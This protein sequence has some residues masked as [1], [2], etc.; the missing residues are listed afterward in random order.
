MGTICLDVDGVV[1]DICASLN[2]E[3]ED[4]RGIFN[5]DYSDW[6]ITPFENNLTKEIFSSKTFWKN[7]KPFADAWYCIN[8]WWSMG[9]DINLITARMNP[10]GRD[11][12]EEWLYNWRISYNNIYFS[13][14]G[15]KLDVIKD[16][17]PIFMI[18][19]NPH[20]VMKI[21]E[22]GIRSLLRRGWYNSEYW[23]DLDSIGSLYEVDF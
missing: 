15:E 8:H 10:S 13:K 23:E 18:E 6:L 14:M 16:M 4:K 11:T 20:E 17:D 19:D 3:L 2:R 5:Y 21:K 1:T 9:H 7:M 22:A 12:L